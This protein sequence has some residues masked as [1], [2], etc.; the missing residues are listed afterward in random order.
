MN[1]A[2]L[3]GRRFG[4]LTVEGDSGRRRDRCVLWRCRC[5]CG[6]AAFFVRRELLSG[7]AQNCGCVPRTPVSKRR[8]EDLTGR[9]F[10]ALIV[11]RRGE[12]DPH[13]RVRWVCRCDCGKEC[14]VSSERLKSGRT[15][16]CGC[17]RTSQSYNANDL[18]GQRFG[19]LT[20]C[21][22]AGSSAQKTVWHCRCDCGNEVDVLGG[23]LIQG[24]TRSCGCLS[25]E[26]SR[27]M[28]DHMHYR[29]NTCVEMLERSQRNWADN[30]AGFR[31][32]LLTKSGAYRVSITFRKTRYNLGS[33]KSYQDAVRARLDAEQ[34]LH[35]GY[36]RAFH[37]YER[38]AAADPA[39]AER[40]P[41]FYD[42]RR[43]NGVFQVST[44]GEEK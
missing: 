41:F 13:G 26:N 34:R 9:R 44:N 16:S 36:I 19:R 39:W 10:G 4:M 3:T 43:V 5:D 21:G 2:D 29:D 24:Q 14:V 15:R 23:S 33:Y 35:A 20:V 27:S 22:R 18:T 7:Q 28:H 8:A 38:H 30:R 37:G 31:G 17:Q 12:N 25:R 11:L 1:S 42:V 32:L 6:Q 40:H